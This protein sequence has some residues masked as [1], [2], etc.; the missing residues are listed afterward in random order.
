MPALPERLFPQ[1]NMYP[2][3]NK[4]PGLVFTLGDW[5]DRLVPRMCGT[6]GNPLPL[7][8]HA[9]TDVSSIVPQLVDLAKNGRLPWY[10]A[11]DTVAPYF[12][13]LCM[14]ADPATNTAVCIDGG[15]VRTVGLSTLLWDVFDVATPWIILGFLVMTVSSSSLSGSVR[16]TFRLA[17]G[18]R[19]RR[20]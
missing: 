15:M 18:S 8:A 3:L 19:T 13:Y 20:H 1:A 2:V 5:L 7:L 4:V 16:L 10:P 14:P 12:G 11:V 6:P 17:A 9:F